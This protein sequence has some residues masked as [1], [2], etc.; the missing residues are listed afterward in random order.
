MKLYFPKKDR[1]HGRYMVST[2]ALHGPLAVFWAY[3]VHHV[4]AYINNCWTP[5]GV[6]WI[7]YWHKRER[8]QRKKQENS[9]G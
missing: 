2:E 6:L 1:G 5:L 8:E 7:I 3:S 4:P 9:L